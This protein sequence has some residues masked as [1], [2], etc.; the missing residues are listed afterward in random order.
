MK[1][2]ELGVLERR[3][4]AAVKRFIGEPEWPR[5]AYAYFRRSWDINLT[6]TGSRAC[7]LFIHG[8][9]AV[10][11]NKDEVI[12]AYK[13]DKLDEYVATWITQLKIAGEI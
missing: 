10:N 4:E 9:P 11:V 13:N 5:T 8:S 2:H 3:F 1:E 6:P 12:S 7:F